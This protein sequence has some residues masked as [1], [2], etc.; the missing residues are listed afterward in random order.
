MTPVSIARFT[1]ELEH[2]KKQMEAGA[3]KHGEYDQRLARMI[4]ELRER[5]LEA[6]RDDVRQA[7]S[8]LAR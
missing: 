7:L 6:E 3:L 8:E 2:L 4:G 1:Q 5:K